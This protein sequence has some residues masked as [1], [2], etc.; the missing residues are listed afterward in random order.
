MRTETEIRACIN[1][2]QI[3]EMRPDT[4]YAQQSYF[5][6]WIDPATGRAHSFPTGTPQKNLLRQIE[7]E[8]SETIQ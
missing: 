3:F 5:D 1:C 6:V 4:V 7:R 8:Q 2:R